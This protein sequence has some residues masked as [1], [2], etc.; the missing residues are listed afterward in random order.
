MAALFIH[1]SLLRR[2]SSLSIF[3]NPIG[4][5]LNRNRYEIWHTIHDHARIHPPQIWNI[6]QFFLFSL[7]N[8]NFE[9]STVEYSIVFDKNF[10]SS[11]AGIEIST[12]EKSRKFYIHWHVSSM[13]LME[14]K[15]IPR[16][17]KI[18][19]WENNKIV[20]NMTRAKKM[21]RLYIGRYGLNESSFKVNIVCSFCSYWKMLHI[22]GNTVHLFIGRNE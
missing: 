5:A 11:Y 14:R 7:Q 9:F 13:I 12:G 1:F 18:F 17:L 10:M 6:W 21:D 3:Y 22:N 4:Y 19:Q 2:N 15:K 20:N 16:D 8:V